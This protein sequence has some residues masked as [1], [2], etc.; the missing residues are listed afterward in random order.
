[1]ADDVGLL[2]DRLALRDLVEAYAHHVDRRE[3]DAAAEL[4]TPDGV[5]RIF[6]RGTD[7]PVRQRAGRA[8]IATAMAG[9]DRYD[10]T[11]HVVANHRVAFDGADAATGEAYC[12]AHHVRD[13]ERPDGTTG[14]SDYV[15][16]IRYLDR[17]AR[18]DEG[19]RIEERHLQLEFTEERPVSGP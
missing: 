18:T 3:P 14:P 7:E 2:L 11:L 15:M 17:Y 5:L 12:L 16:H 9:L 8:D 4:F 10:V 6:N 13:V 1:M 19:W